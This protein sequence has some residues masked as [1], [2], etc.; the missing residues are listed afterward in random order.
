MAVATK[1]SPGRPAAALP[2]DVVRVATADFVAHRRID[3]QRIAAELGLARAT[4]YRWF[5]SRE[6]LIGEVIVE[7]ARG[8]IR[9]ARR[10]TRGHGASALLRIFDRVN[11]DVMRDHALRAWVEQEREHALRILTARDG[12]VQSRVVEEIER[13]IR[14]EVD[15]GHYRPPI[16]PAT[17]A[18][19]I[20]RL[21]ES[22]L[23][24]DAAL[25]DESDVVKLRAVH[26]VLLGVETRRGV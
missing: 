15:G 12:P 4:V 3:V 21:T 25:G 1:R 6:G 2:E 8:R 7:L 10:R 17:L 19:A 14:E 23:Y 22:F 26:G 9:T 20:V 11:R 18:Y 13:V 5:G 16:A 24:P